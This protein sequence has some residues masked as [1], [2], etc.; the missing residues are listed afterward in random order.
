W[1]FFFHAEDGIRAGHVTGVQTCALPISRHASPARGTDRRRPHAVE[2][3]PWLK[4]IAREIDNGDAR[5]V[6][7]E[8]HRDA[9]RRANAAPDRDLL[10]HLAERRDNEP[11]AGRMDLTR[12]NSRAPRRKR[13]EPW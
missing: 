11:R 1:R 12:R 6:V 9:R 3:E 7:S 4:D 8:H 5:A 2:V 10:L 13:D